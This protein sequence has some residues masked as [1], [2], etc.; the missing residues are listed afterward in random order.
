MAT[1]EAKAVSFITA[2][3]LLVS[4]GMTI[5]KACGRI[6]SPIIRHP[7][8]PNAFEAGTVPGIF[9]LR[10]TGITQ[11][12]LTVNYTVSGTASRAMRTNE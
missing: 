5:L 8:S 6:T 7:D 11:P 3:A 12:S 10:R 4:G 9:S 2:I 1:T